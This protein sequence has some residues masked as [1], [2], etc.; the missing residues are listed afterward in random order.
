MV[1]C[2]PGVSFSSFSQ[3]SSVS[4]ED[5][6]FLFRCYAEWEVEQGEAA[7]AL[8]ALT[9]MCEGSYTPPSKGKGARACLVADVGIEC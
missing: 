3:A 6:V 7:L 9:A 8:E 1:V 5:V 2:F 4:S